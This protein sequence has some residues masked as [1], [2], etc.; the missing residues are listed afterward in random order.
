MCKGKV[1]SSFPNNK[2]TSR[3]TTSEIS[4]QPSQEQFEINDREKVLLKEL[5]DWSERSSA[6]HWVLGKPLGA[7][8]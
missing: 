7:R 1:K 4:R 2:K 5:F 8:G 6:T 3:N